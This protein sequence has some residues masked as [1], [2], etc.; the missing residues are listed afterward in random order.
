[1]H[2]SCTSLS[3]S[4][5]VTPGRTARAAISRTSRPSCVCVCVCACAVCVRVCVCMCAWGVR[6]GFHIHSEKHLIDGE[7]C[8]F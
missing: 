4:S 3:T 7:S 8:L 6:V 1:M 5:V 2:A